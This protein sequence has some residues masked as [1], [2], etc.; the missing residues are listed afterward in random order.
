MTPPG[1]IRPA[2][3][4]AAASG[5]VS[6]FSTALH[7]PAPKRS[8]FHSRTTSL[9]TGGPQDRVLRKSTWRAGWELREMESESVREERSCRLLSQ[10][11]AVPRWPCA[12][13]LLSPGPPGLRARGQECFRLQPSRS[14][15]ESPCSDIL[16]GNL[17]TQEC[18][19]VGT[20]LAPPP[21]ALSQ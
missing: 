15:P 2:S 21:M 7:R 18:T 13:S 9:A 16:S 14:W 3:R 20:S 8:C 17:S 10:P 19:R 11:G 4:A 6:P 1:P 5:P 12:A